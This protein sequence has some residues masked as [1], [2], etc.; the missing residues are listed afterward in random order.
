MKKKSLPSLFPTVFCSPWSYPTSHF[1]ASFFFVLQEEEIRIDCIIASVTHIS[2]IRFLHH[3]IRRSSIPCA[4]VDT[5]VKNFDN[6][7]IISRIRSKQ[8]H[9]KALLVVVLGPTLALLLACRHV[10]L[11]QHPAVAAS[12]TNES[13]PRF[14]F[15]SHLLPY[16]NHLNPTCG[17]ESSRISPPRPVPIDLSGGPGDGVRPGGDW[18]GSGGREC[19]G[20]GSSAGCE[21]G[22]SGEEE[23]AWGSHGTDEQGEGKGKGEVGT[24]WSEDRVE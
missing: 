10:Q 2:G 7:V 11:H 18:V 8:I 15:G 5:N 9:V 20:A 24:G 21:G 19:G 14:N 4:S 13:I 22:Y 23:H 17:Q 12:S 3:H 6:E 1:F 16:P